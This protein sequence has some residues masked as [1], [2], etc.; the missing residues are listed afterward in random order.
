MSCRFRSTVLLVLG[1]LL[2]AACPASGKAL[3]A[4]EWIEV[5]TPNFRIRSVL[6]EKDSIELVR[7]LEMLRVAV[8]RVTNISR[9]DSPI[10]TEIYA[11]R[12]SS[13]FKSLGISSNMAG[14]FR[15][16]LRKNLIV[17][18]NLR[19]KEEIHFIKHEYV[20]F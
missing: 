14:I 18:R 5:R 10:P 17:I 4:R 19:G 16:G 15:T 6:S 12:R 1:L 3:E 13:D 9:T 2:V 11:L 20:H 8:S 7:H